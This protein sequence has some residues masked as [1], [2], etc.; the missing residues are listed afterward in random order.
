MSVAGTRGNWTSSA[1]EGGAARENTA[2]AVVVAR[3]VAIGATDAE[4]ATL[5]GAI[6]SINA[7]GATDFERT[8][9]R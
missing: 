3:K 8:G 2:G 6:A 4:G 5:A 1:A 7:A 9:R